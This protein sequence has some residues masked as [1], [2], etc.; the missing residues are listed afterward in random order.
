[1]EAGAIAVQ[2]QQNASASA[3][4]PVNAICQTA[5][6]WDVVT[7]KQQQTSDNLSQVLHSIVATPP[8]GNLRNVTCPLRAGHSFGQGMGLR[9]YSTG[10]LYFQTKLCQT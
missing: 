1:M 8:N 3:T 4:S 2:L 9:I 7:E 10:V 5:T 6:V